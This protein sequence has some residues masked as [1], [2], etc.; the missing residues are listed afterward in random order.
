MADDEYTQYSRTL[1]D[2]PQMRRMVAVGKVAP[3]SARIWMRSDMIGEHV[4]T[5]NP[6][7]KPE[8]K[9]E[10]RITL[11]ALEPTDGTQ[12][13]LI[14]GLNPL[15]RYDYRVY[16]PGGA[17]IGQGRFETPPSKPED[18]PDKVS[19]AV[20]SCH[21]PFN[22]DN[23]LSD[24]RMRLLT[25]LDRILE[26]SDV[27]FILLVGDQIYSDYPEQRSLFYQHYIEKWL[28]QEPSILMWTE[29]DIR[30]AYQER[31]RIFWEM[32]EVQY[33]YANYPCY[34]ILDD[35]EIV[36][37]W[38]VE[39]EH[40]TPNYV[41]LGKAARAAYF[42]YQGSRV[43]GL[44]KNMPASFHYSFDYGNIGVF[45]MD[46]RSQRKPGKS[47]QMFG[48]AQFN[49]LRKFLERGDEKRVL[50]IVAS[51]P[52]IHLPDWLTKWGDLILK[53][54]VNFRDRW[55]YEPN[56]PQRDQFLKL[57]YE[58]QKNNPRQRI[59]LVSGDIHIGCAFSIEWQGSS[60]QPTLY[61]FTSS[62]ISNRLHRFEADFSKLGPSLERT[63]ACQGGS[64]A[65]TRLLAA[66]E[67]G[68]HDQNPFGGLNVGIID[69]YKEE[70]ESPVVF[71]LVG[72]PEGIAGGPYHKD[73]FVSQRL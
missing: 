10:Q 52:V 18:T 43:L 41:K 65:T 71:R 47:S 22:D 67:D 39:E 33:F 35:H 15:T 36:D 27:K 31:Y 11:E 54:S 29:S 37:D 17:L 2:V 51:L 20:M 48:S 16:A 25:V 61:Q 34:P 60:P 24:R 70:T 64:T 40:R 4:L 9:A 63:V 5:F 6:E 72:Y 56:I 26:D 7:E 12:T 30:K 3:N 44:L 42:D 58:H 23:S 66:A 46:L 59:I 21:Q 8:A 73:M 28:G 50:L 55:S 38:G 1:F 45:V 57:V 32:K 69:I 49:D 68:D 53:K 19:I 14:R 62:A 13:V